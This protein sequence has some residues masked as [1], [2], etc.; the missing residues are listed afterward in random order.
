MLHLNQELAKA[1]NPQHLS[2]L[3]RGSNKA[4]H[5]CEDFK[6]QTSE[7]LTEVGGIFRCKKVKGKRSQKTVTLHYGRLVSFIMQGLWLAW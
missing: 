4:K 6:R 5:A 2:F 7:S 1:Q 3:K